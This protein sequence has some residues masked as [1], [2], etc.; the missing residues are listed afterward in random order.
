MFCFP[1][2]P[3]QVAEAARVLGLSPAE[4]QNI[5]NNRSTKSLYGTTAISIATA[6]I[7]GG[8]NLES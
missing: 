4:Q 8:E 6:T 3:N 2:E 7:M 5:V 1:K